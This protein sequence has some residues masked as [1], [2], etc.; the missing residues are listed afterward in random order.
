MITEGIREEVVKT[1]SLLTHSTPFYVFMN[2]RVSNID[3]VI[4]FFRLLGLYFVV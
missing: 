4:F 1:V 2:E 3:K